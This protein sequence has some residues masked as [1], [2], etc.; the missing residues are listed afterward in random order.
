[1]K[2]S[3][4]QVLQLLGLA[5]RA[6]QLTSGEPS[7][8]KAIRNDEARLVVLASDAGAATAKKVTDKCHYYQVALTTAFTANEISA[9]VGAQRKV[10]AVTQ[11]GFAKKMTSLLN[12]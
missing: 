4:Q 7:V 2:S 10:L 8:V 11:S 5:K 3:C 6:G 9:A 1:M 12:N